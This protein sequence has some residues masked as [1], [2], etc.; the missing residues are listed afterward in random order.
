MMNTVTEIK[1][2]QEGIN[3][4]LDNTKESISELKME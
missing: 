3:N 4:R 1:N 2:S